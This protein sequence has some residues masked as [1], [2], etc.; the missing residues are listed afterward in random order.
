MTRLVRS[1]VRG[2]N[3]FWFEPA[4]A[5]DLGIGRLLFFSG[6]FLFYLPIDFS[7]WGLVSRAFWMP[8]PAF[9]L[10]HL[11]PASAPALESLSTV[12]RIAL[13]LSAVGLFTRSSM[14]VSAVLGFYL[15]GLPHN[16]GHTYHFDALLV[17]ALAIMAFSRAGDAWSIDA[18]FSR[19]N[20]SPSAEYT[21]PIRMIWT[22]MALVFFAAGLAKLRHGGL[23]WITSANMEM[24]LRRAA[25]HTSDADPIATLG[26]WIASHAWLT[27]L[28]AAM[29]VLVELGFITALWSRAARAVMVPAAALLLIGIRITMGPTFGGFLIANVFWVPWRAIGERLAIR[30]RSNAI[31]ASTLAQPRAG[32]A[33]LP[34]VAALTVLPL[35]ERV[36]APPLR[37]SDLD[38]L[39]AP[40]P[41]QMRADHP[42]GSRRSPTIH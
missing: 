37:P 12:W 30:S 26:L 23:E 34:H 9:N 18:L 3:S 22:A 32:A 4:H 1:L 33:E 31:D 17:L 6:L 5:T 15:L 40:E 25:Y 42:T 39:N 27:R 14:I 7:E 11:G 21:W 41:R 28:L 16:F 19:P 29:T 35:I 24:I 36:P 38:F 2:W 20:V 13:I 10:L 8:L